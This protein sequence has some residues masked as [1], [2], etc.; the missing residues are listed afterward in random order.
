MLSTKQTLAGL[1]LLASGVIADEAACG[2]QPC[3]SY[4]DKF[5]P[6]AVACIEKFAVQVGCTLG[7]HTCECQKQLD[8]IN[9]GAVE[10]L[11][12]TCTEE[13]VVDT[14]NNLTPMCECVAASPSVPCPTATATETL[15]APTHTQAC[16]E[17]ECSLPTANECINACID[18]FLTE[19][20]CNTYE[21]W[22][23]YCKSFRSISSK[24]FACVRACG[25]DGTA[26]SNAAGK[27]CDCIAKPCPTNNPTTTAPPPTTEAPPTT[28]PPPTTEP[29]AECPHPCEASVSLVP[30]CATDCIVSAAT[31]VGC[32]GRD[33]EC[34]CSSS[35]AI[36][37]SAFNCVVGACGLEGAV[38]VLDPV[39][40]LCKCVAASPATSCAGEPTDTAEPTKTDEPEPT[41][42][43]CDDDSDSDDDEPTETGE[44]CPSSSFVTKTIEVTTSICDDDDDEPTQEPSAVPSCSHDGCHG[45]DGGDEGSGDEGSGSDDEGGEGGGPKPS[46]TGGN[47]GGEPSETGGK[48]P[49][50]TGAA[51]VVAVGSGLAGLMAAVVAFL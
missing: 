35:A 46:V 42:T 20:G 14:V 38:G 33:F 36:Q 12:E 15:P 43:A 48:P 49:V 37:A 13:E 1:F 44:P 26:F 40:N 3:Q 16:P 11:S 28:T 19:A 7:D 32:D 41:T 21:D 34:R 23:C 30:K 25:A 29:P 8:I 5:A 17:S 27:G 18:P 24:A 22:N 50:A 45:G 9:A 10:C 39:S 4:V 31:A 6:C 51:G 47:P 2:T